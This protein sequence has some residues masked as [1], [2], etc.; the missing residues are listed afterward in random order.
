[1]K[2][3]IISCVGVM[4][5]SIITYYTT[6]KIQIDMS[7]RTIK[8]ENMQSFK[9]YLHDYMR[10]IA[11]RNILVKYHQE[12]KV[13]DEEFKKEDDVFQESLRSS[14]RNIVLISCYID[15]ELIQ[16]FEC[17]NNDL[18]KRI[19]EYYYIYIDK[20]YEPVYEDVLD[21]YFTYVNSIMSIMN[22]LDVEIRKNIDGV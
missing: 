22:D 7:K 10:T 5:G 6:K 1:M 9:G 20:L 14:V 17:I 3:L 11:L 19:F 16:R 4:L 12:H 15:K 18:N 13:T 8:I 2:E 21:E